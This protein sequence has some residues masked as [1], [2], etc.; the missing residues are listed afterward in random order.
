MNYSNER[1]IVSAQSGYCGHDFPPPLARAQWRQSLARS[2][3]END[4]PPPPSILSHSIFQIERSDAAKR[5]VQVNAYEIH[6]NPGESFKFTVSINTGRLALKY[7]STLF[8]SSFNS[9]SHHQYNMDCNLPNGNKI[10][11]LYFRS[12]EKRM[13]FSDQERRED[14]VDFNF[15]HVRI[16]FKLYIPINRSHF[17]F[18]KNRFD[19]SRLG[20]RSFPLLSRDPMEV[21]IFQSCSMKFTYYFYDG[22]FQRSGRRLRRARR[23]NRRDTNRNWSK[24]N[25]SP[26]K[27][28]SLSFF[29][30]LVLTN[31]VCIK[32][33]A[34]YRT[35]E[36]SIRMEDTT[37]KFSHIR[38]SN[39]TIHTA[40]TKMKDGKK[41]RRREVFSSIQT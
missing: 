13:I 23:I 20:A 24:R 14:R 10:E 7:V 30:S 26:L 1:S 15:E 16:P 25:L 27:G 28:E 33:T 8:S 6:L 19:F 40:Q 4:L 36:E 41:G 32:W 3:G 37:R 17:P 38:G 39:W 5:C 31:K 11:A 9:N 12:S 34:Y 18:D 2:E 21:S 22:S 29:H 35:I